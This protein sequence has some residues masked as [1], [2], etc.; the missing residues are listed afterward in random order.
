MSTRKF[1]MKLYLRNINALS[2]LRM[3]TWC[4]ALTT[5]TDGIP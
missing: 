3:R 1:R 5:V 4:R 2:G